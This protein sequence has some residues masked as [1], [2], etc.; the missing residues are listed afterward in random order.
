V[1]YWLNV[2]IPTQTA[3]LHT[4]QCR[5]ATTIEPTEY[6]GIGQLKRDGGCFRS[7]LRQNRNSLLKQENRSRGGIGV[8]TMF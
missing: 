4:N 5:H 6:R 1:F 7:K 3:M 8:E 2:D